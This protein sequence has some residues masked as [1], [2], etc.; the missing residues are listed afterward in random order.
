[1]L[2]I[3]PKI[4]WTYYVKYVEHDIWNM[5]NMLSEI[6]WTFYLKYVEHIIW[7][8]LN[9]S[10][11]Y[12]TYLKYVEH[13]WNMLNISQICWI[14]Y[15]KIPTINF[16]IY[17]LYMQ[18]IKWMHLEMS[19]LPNMIVWSGRWIIDIDESHLFQIKICCL[20][21]LYVGYNW[22]IEIIFITSLKRRIWNEL[23]F[24][25]TTLTRQLCVRLPAR[26]SSTTSSSLLVY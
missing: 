2:N 8:M 24:S 14:Y 13:I 7:N 11:T 1:M 26:V 15:L 25:E 6:C 12:W 4:C 17:Y 16:N 10:E 21:L 22:E 3:L 19:I 9:I 20:Q 5:L 23:Q 18:L